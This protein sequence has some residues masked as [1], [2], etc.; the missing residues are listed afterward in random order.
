MFAERRSEMSLFAHAVARSVKP[1]ICPRTVKLAELEEIRKPKMKIAR[2]EPIQI[3]FS[4]LRSRS[5]FTSLRSYRSF[6]LLSALTAPF[7]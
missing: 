7:F 1:A 6:S 5:L 2:M 3:R 4:Q